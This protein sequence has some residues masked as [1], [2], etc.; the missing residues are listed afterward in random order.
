MIC[1][2]CNGNDEDCF[3]CNG[4]GRMCDVCGEAVDACLCD[5]GPT[6][7]EEGGS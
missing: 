6:D 7:D 2:D 4:M 1:E 3:N 5:D